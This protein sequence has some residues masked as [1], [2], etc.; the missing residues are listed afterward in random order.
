VATPTQ[1]FFLKRPLREAMSNSAAAIVSMAWLGAIYK[2]AT[3]SQHGITI[4]E[5]LRIAVCIIPGAII[6]GYIGRRLMHTLPKNI[7]R[8]IFILVCAIAA[9]KLLTVAPST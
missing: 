2:N 1:Q 5:S 6:G 8:A 3:L 4:T 7:V 9:V